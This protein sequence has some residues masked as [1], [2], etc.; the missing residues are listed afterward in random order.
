MTPQAWGFWRDVLAQAM[1]TVIG[2]AILA[3]A[4]ILV[5]LIDNVSLLAVSAF[6]ALLG[7]VGVVVQFVFLTRWTREVRRRER[8][9]D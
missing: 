7:A 2:G 4:G 5:G 8:E 6:F 1:G 9:T 3:L